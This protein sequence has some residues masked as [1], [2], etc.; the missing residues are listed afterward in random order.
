MLTSLKIK[1]FRALDDFD[2][3]KLGRVNLIVGKNNAGKSSVLEAL[4]I[5]AGNANL[6]LLENIAAEHGEKY[7]LKESDR[8]DDNAAL[9]FEDFF[10]GRCI[11][12]T[13][14]QA[15]EIGDPSGDDLLK[16][17]HRFYTEERATQTNANGEITQSTHI[18]WVEKTDLA[19][20]IGV[21]FESALFVQKGK[22]T[23]MLRFDLNGR[24]G[25]TSSPVDLPG[26]Q[27]CSLVPTQLVSIDEL[28]DDWDKIALTAHQTIVQDALR[29]IMPTFEA[30]TFVRNEDDGSSIGGRA[31]RLRRTAKVKLTNRE[32]L[33]PLN[34]LGEG[35]LRVLQLALKV[36]PAK[37]GF[38]LIDEFESGLHYS[39]Q[40]KIWALVFELARKLDIQVFATTH[41]WDCIENFAQIAMQQ[42]DIEGVL[43]NIG[44]SIRT[45]DKGRIVATVFDQN[46]LFE[47]TQADIEVR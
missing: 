23:S 21:Y 45:S 30:I 11:P 40:G 28:A 37:G 29:L 6:P 34:S 16:I 26:A 42:S 12:D 22:Q 33:V 5:F 47:L 13:D 14:G 35:M 2:V 32:K 18:K 41:S 39:V 10:S 8:G 19:V 25:V 44:A 27:P 9:P 15:I 17:E 36:F 24:R 20:R 38:L 7:M 43:L 31:P 46:E 3:P 1:N 4:R